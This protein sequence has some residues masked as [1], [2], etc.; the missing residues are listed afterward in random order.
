MCSLHVHYSLQI[1][2]LKPPTVIMV[3][4]FEG[5]ASVNVVT[6]HI[7]MINSNL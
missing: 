5:W 4:W 7:I 2:C 6:V 3:N 1:L